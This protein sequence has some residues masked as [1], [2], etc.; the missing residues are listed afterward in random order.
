MP[1]GE[2][3]NNDNEFNRLFASCGV[4]IVAVALIFRLLNGIIGFN[5]GV[6][7]V[8]TTI[9]HDN[10]SEREECDCE[11]VFENANVAFA[12]QIG[13]RKG[14]IRGVCG[15]PHDGCFATIIFGFKRDVIR[16]N[17]GFNFDFNCVVLTAIITNDNETENEY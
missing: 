13:L 2:I 5:F 7:A 12:T 17:N 4:T 11:C 9:T 8:R 1:A 3:G 15:T 14:L 16:F 10:E 6:F